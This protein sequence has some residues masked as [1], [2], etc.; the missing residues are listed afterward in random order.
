MLPLPTCICYSFR[1]KRNILYKF[2]IRVVVNARVSVIVMDSGM[3][4]R[5]GMHANDIWRINIELRQN[6]AILRYNDKTCWIVTRAKLCGYLF[7]THE[8]KMISMI[9]SLECRPLFIRMTFFVCLCVSVVVHDFPAFSR[10]QRQQK[11]SPKRCRENER[12]KEWVRW[13]TSTGNEPTDC[14][15][16]ALCMSVMRLLRILRDTLDKILP[17]RATR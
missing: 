8:T 13:Y 6:E 10:F 9:Y 3:S 11:R 1:L 4:E 5:N 12:E 17:T 7:N 15:K 16:R 14:S 2:L